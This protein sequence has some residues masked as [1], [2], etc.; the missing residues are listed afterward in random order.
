MGGGYDEVAEYAHHLGI[1]S[2]LNQELFCLAKKALLAPLPRHWTPVKD[3][4]NGIYYFNQ[5][6]GE[7]SWVHPVDA[8]LKEFI[9]R[10]KRREKDAADTGSP[11]VVSN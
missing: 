5:E 3:K 8:S 11:S 7:S 2:D 4:S 10:S 6:T 1:G 9:R